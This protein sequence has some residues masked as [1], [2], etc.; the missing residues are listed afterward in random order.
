[1]LISSGWAERVVGLV[2]H[3]SVE[4][5]VAVLAVLK[6]GGAYLPIDPISDRSCGIHAG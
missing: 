2:L 6:A 3:R 5:V 1:V 4:M